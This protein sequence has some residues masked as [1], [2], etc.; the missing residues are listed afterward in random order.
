MRSDSKI[1]PLKLSAIEGKVIAFSTAIALVDSIA[2]IASSVLHA[3][4]RSGRWNCP[5]QLHCSPRHAT[6][7]Q[8]TPRHATPRH[9]MPRHATPRH[10]SHLLA[11]SHIA[12]I[13]SHRKGIRRAATRR[14]GVLL[15]QRSCDQSITST[16]TT[17]G[18]TRIH[19]S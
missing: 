14:G 5:Y 12:C 4:H 2:S 6:P 10:A 8:A 15:S 9:A 17:A 13:A 3:Q 1:A 11:S 7:R 19:R 18:N 16:G